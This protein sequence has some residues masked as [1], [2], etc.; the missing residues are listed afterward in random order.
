[1]TLYHGSGVIVTEPTIVVSQKLSDFGP[2]FY[3]TNDEVKA[4]ERAQYVI[5]QKDAFL[6]SN[7]CFISEYEIDLNDKSLKIKKFD[8][9]NLE[10]LDQILKSHKHVPI[11]DYDIV[12]GPVADARAKKIIKS[13][14][15]QLKI[16]QNDPKNEEEILILKKRTIAN[17]IPKGKTYSQYVMI[18]PQAF[19][20]IEYKKAYVFSDKGPLLQTINKNELL[21]IQKL[22]KQSKTTKPQLWKGFKR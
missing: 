21:D 16:L 15:S 4:W 11:N 7:L 5:R 1:M 6:G 12:I 19:E 10:W 8:A 17:L 20:K 22:Q 3:T 9:P 14:S 2:G 18:S 13:F